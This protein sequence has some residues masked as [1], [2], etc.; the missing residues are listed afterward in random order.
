MVKIGYPPHA[1]PS[2]VDISIKFSG[3]TF[4]QRTEQ[5]KVDKFALNPTTSPQR[6]TLI[7]KNMA[8]IPFV[9]GCIYKFKDDQLIILFGNATGGYSNSFGMD[10]SNKGRTF[11]YLEKIS[12]KKL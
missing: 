4:T 2:G 11:G 12:S 8:G 9:S 3:D 10:E 5:D 1:I 6:L 7:G